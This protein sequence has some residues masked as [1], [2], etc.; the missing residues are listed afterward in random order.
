MVI[1][2]TMI[3]EGVLNG[4]YVPAVEF[5]P[6]AWNGRPV[7][8]GH[9]QVNGRDVSANSP[10]ILEKFA[11]GQI[12][13]AKLTDD[14]LTAEAWID[15]HRMGKLGQNQLL[16]NLKKEVKIEVSTGYFAFTEL[17][18]GEIKGN[19]YNE[20]HRDIKPDH[21]ALLPDAIGACSIQDGCGTF[22][23]R[24][25]M[26]IKE[27]LEVITNAFKPTEDN[28]MDK[29]KIVEGLIANKHFEE[30]EKEGLLALSEKN[31][32]TLSEAFEKNA[33]DKKENEDDAEDEKDK[34][35]KEKM[36]DQNDKKADDKQ[37]N[38]SA[39]SDED[40]AAL[41]FAKNQYNEHKKTLIAKITANSNMTA[42]QLKAM[43]AATLET[44][45]N[46]LKVQG[47]YSGRGFPNNQGDSKEEERVKSMKAES[48][49]SI[50]Q[51]SKKKGA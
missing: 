45:A 46:G 44:I 16:S 11:V 34:M 20:V 23:K 50:V 14:K 48:V 4:A 33:K 47:D 12:F 27:A 39:L 10:E 40:K 22:N 2:L 42:E 29:N 6:Q 37:K 26:K 35:D 18:A 49:L 1:P 25:N 3:V 31:L 51:N 5:V 17:Q 7:T 32:K 19:K 43:D 21:L 13:G 30:S 8:I 15:T 38:N 9:P 28:K 24:F 36:K 41:A